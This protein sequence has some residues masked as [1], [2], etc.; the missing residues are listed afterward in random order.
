[1]AFCGGKPS[2][3]SSRMRS[4]ISTLASTDMPTVSAMPA[5]PGRLMVA[6]SRDI[7]ANTISRF[8]NSAMQVIRPNIR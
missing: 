6:P 2:R 7:S 3:N 5:R 4:L 8:I 1:M